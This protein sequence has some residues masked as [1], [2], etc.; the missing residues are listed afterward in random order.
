MFVDIGVSQRHHSIRSGMSVSLR[1][2][3]VILLNV[4][5]FRSDGSGKREQV[6]AG[7]SLVRREARK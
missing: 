6:L 2:S 7:G 3:G 1:W 4:E 5:T